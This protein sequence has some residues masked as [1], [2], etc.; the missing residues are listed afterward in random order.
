MNHSKFFWEV[1]NQYAAQIRG[2]WARGYTGDGL[3]GRG[4][5]LGTGEWEKNTILPEEA[6]P[7]HLCG[8][9]YRSRRRKRKAKP[10]LSYHERKERRILKKFGANGVRL[11]ADDEVK[12]ELEKGKRVQGK[13]R[14]AGSARGRELRAAAALARFEQQKKEEAEEEVDFNVKDE[15]E[16]ASGS[17]TENDYEEDLDRDQQDALDVDG[18]LL[19]DRDGKGM[20]KVC[21]DENPND[22]D[23][24]REVLELQKSLNVSRPLTRS[25][26]PNDETANSSSRVPVTIKLEN[27][28]GQILNNIKRATEKHRMVDEVAQQQAKREDAGSPHTTAVSTTELTTCSVCFFANPNLAMTCTICSHVLDPERVPNSWRCDGPACNPSY[29]NSGDCGV[30]GI[31]GLR[32]PD[33]ANA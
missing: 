1:R 24:K 11:G 22:D 7:E 16:T 3:W 5:L 28:T 10:T 23:A 18:K 30:C 25:R 29:V 12:A 21:E 9:T 15:D 14:V 8:G 6:L 4:A 26:G 19:V 33:A 13:P 31:C 27:E 2:L 17:E 32:K 20:I